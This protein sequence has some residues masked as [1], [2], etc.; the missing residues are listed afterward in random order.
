MDSMEQ[1]I[2][3]IDYRVILVKK[4][5]YVMKTPKP[6][7]SP[8]VMGMMTS[9]LSNAGCMSIERREVAYKSCIVI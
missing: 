7:L 3:C 6:F 4:V 8:T 1:G 5:L 9:S 2:K